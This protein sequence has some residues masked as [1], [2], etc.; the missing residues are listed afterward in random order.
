MKI[1]DVT[2]LALPLTIVAC[3]SSKLAP[4]P[5]PR[6]ASVIAVAPFVDTYSWHPY[7]LT[8]EAKISPDDLFRFVRVTENGDAE[9]IWQQ[10]GE[11][12][13]LKANTSR[14]AAVTAK[15][16]MRIIRSDFVSQSVEFE[17]LTTN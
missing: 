15:V 7:H 4:A 5:N 13:Y 9:L 3:S 8:R 10:N 1:I 12:I 2:F 11:H 17:W 16:Y 6:S 14:K